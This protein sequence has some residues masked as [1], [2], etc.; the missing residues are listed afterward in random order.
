[1][2]FLI[3]YKVIMAKLKIIHN[4]LYKNY[5]NFSSV[6]LVLLSPVTSDTFL[7]RPDYKF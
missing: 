1:M 4:N 7:F 6:E 5:K 2:N 3:E